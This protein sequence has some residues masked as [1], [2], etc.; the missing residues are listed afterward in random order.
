MKH[1]LQHLLHNSPTPQNP[2]KKSDPQGLTTAIPY[3]SL[4]L[5]GTQ[6]MSKEE[7]Q[8][9]TSDLPADTAPMSILLLARV[10]IDTILL[11]NE[12]H[13]HIRGAFVLSVI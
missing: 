6:R 11:T 9:N 13:T 4:I 1:Y 2:S 12:Y 8:G 3:V 7:R 10:L 5:C